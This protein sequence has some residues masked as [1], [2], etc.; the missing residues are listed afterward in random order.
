[1]E[2]LLITCSFH[3]LLSVSHKWYGKQ[4]HIF[5]NSKSIDLSAKQ[6]AVD[7]TGHQSG[8]FLWFVVYFFYSYKAVSFMHKR[9]TTTTTTKVCVCGTLRRIG[10]REKRAEQTCI[11]N[12]HLLLS[13]WSPPDIRKYF[14]C[15]RSLELILRW[16]LLSLLHWTCLL[17]LSAQ[18]EPVTIGVT[19]EYALLTNSGVVG[20][21][22]ILQ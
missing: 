13:S 7:V 5:L 8:V 12:H 20:E 1:M 17:N 3:W 10:V 2:D 14:L 19:Q 16:G 22:R 9:K 21:Q 18:L 15:P 4:R 11:S 6:Q